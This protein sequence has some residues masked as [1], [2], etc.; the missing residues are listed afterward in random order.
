[1]IRL[2][3]VDDQTLFREGVHTLLSIHDDVE[4]V[5]EAENGRQAIEKTA[6]HMPDVI[7]MDLRM[8]G[9]GGVATTKEIKEKFPESRVIVLTTFDDDDSIFDALRAGAV[10][11]LLKDVSSQKL[12]EAIRITAAGGSFLQPSVASKIVAGISRQPAAPAPQ[13]L[14]EPLSKR[15][16]E[17]LGHIGRGSSNREIA[18]QLFLSEGTVKNHVTNILGKMGVRDRTQAALMGKE[19][20]LI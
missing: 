7:L 13:T 1:M 15:E 16:I 20:G 6:E 2:L 3:L 9:M 18:A 4:V 12:V 10:G 8:P 11:Y 5:A 17:I 19:L 14:V